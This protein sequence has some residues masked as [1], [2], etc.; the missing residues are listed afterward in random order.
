[1][2]KHAALLLWLVKFLLGFYALQVYSVMPLEVKG[3]GHF[4]QCLLTDV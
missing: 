1:M 2:L 4:C 3:V